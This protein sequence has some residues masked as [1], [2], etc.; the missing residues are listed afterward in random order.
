MGFIRINPTEAVTLP[1][2]EKK[3]IK[4]LEDEELTVFLQA[5][6]KNDK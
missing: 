3:Q 4:P 5:I 6:L 2:I 1:R